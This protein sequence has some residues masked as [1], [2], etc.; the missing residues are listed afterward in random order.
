MAQVAAC[1]LHA[2]LHRHVDHHD[3][4]TPARNWPLI[5]CLLMLLWRGAVLHSLAFSFMVVIPAGLQQMKEAPLMVPRPSS[6]GTGP[7]RSSKAAHMVPAI[8]ACAASVTILL[9]ASTMR[10]AAVHCPGS[11][12]PA[13]QVLELQQYTQCP[14]KVT[15]F[16][17]SFW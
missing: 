16:P 10:G 7:R 2:T 3:L 11:L 6:A 12:S 13:P 8:I 9:W 1:H 17:R 14:S 15:P 4:V 5:D